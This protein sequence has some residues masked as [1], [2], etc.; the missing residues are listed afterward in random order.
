MTC[1]WDKSWEP[2]H[3]L[4]GPCDWVQCLKPPTPP[5]STN[6]RVTDWD[7]QPIP[8]GDPIR[9]VCKRGFQFEEDPAQEEQVYSCQDGT[10]PETVRGFFDV[11]QEEDEWPRCV[12]GKRYFTLST[13]FVQPY[14]GPLCPKPPEV[15]EDGTLAFEPKVFPQ[16]VAQ[17]CNIEGETMEIKCHSFLSIYVRQGMY[18]RNYTNEK[19]LC[20][21]EKP[22]DLKGVDSE[23]DFCLRHLNWPARKNCHGESICIVPVTGDMDKDWTDKFDLQCAPLKKELRVDYICGMF[24]TKIHLSLKSSS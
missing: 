5:A 9:Y 10:A 23:G 11:P 22:D 17:A 16:E 24:G 13:K 20:D 14:A 18:G 7:S 4:P 19:K 12:R 3:K 8:F 2:S 6:L 15:P 1:L 21:G